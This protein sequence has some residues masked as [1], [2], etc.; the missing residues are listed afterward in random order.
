MVT[1]VGSCVTVIR[2]HGVPETTPLRSQSAI[3]FMSAIFRKGL[4]LV[5]ER[6]CKDR[7]D[8]RGRHVGREW[9]QRPAVRTGCVSRRSASPAKKRR[10]RQSVDAEKRFGTCSGRVC[11]EQEG[12]GGG[13]GGGSRKAKGV[14]GDK[15]A[16]STEKVPSRRTSQRCRTA[17]GRLTV[18]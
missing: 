2:S 15:G 17:S 13:G 14:I 16:G 18:N 1:A 3:S 9:A 12:V 8:V 5:R 4:T 6:K 7:R 11:G 10:S